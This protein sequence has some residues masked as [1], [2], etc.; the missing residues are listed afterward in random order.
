MIK[1]VLL[2]LAPVLLAEE[3][4]ARAA[5]PPQGAI[6]PQGAVNALATPLPPP[7]VT[8]EEA[9]ELDNLKLESSNLDL[10]IQLAKLQ[11]NSKIQEYSVRVLKAHPKDNMKFDQQMMKWVN[12]KRE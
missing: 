6:P 3:K 8:H 12:A 2:L 1:I 5:S 11:L 10:Q 4:P 7:Q 9:L